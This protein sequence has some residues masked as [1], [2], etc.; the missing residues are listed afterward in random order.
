[1]SHGS[2]NRSATLAAHRL[3]RGGFALPASIF[4]LMV[5]A[6]LIT[7]GFYLAG[8]ESRI[9]Q[10]SHRATQAFYL[11][12]TGM[13]EVLAAWTPAQ[14]NLG[15]WDTTSACVACQGEQGD[16]EWLVT[17][18]RVDDLLYLV[19]S[20][21]EITQ[22]GRLA[23]ASRVLAQLA[24]GGRLELVESQAAVTTQ[25]QLEMSGNSTVDGRDTNGGGSNWFMN[26]GS[27]ACPAASGGRPAILVDEDAEV[28]TG[29]NSQTLAPPGVDPIARDDGMTAESMEMFE[30][31]NWEA[32]TS[33]ANKY[34]EASG[35]HSIGP[36]LSGSEC[37]TTDPLN[38][39]APVRLT[40][41][42]RTAS[43]ACANFFPIIHIKVPDN[44]DRFQIN[45]NSTGQGILLVEGNLHLNGDFNWAG[46]IYVKGRFTNNGGTGIYGSVTSEGTEITTNQDEQS[47]SG[48]ALITYSSCGLSKAISGA[49][50][51]LPLSPVANRG[52]ADLSAGG[53]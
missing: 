50:G 43:E 22:G 6:V 34:I 19:E 31:D 3:G 45:A 12:E 42:R 46:P 28:D 17:I 33:L 35:P 36:S 14:S 32:L 53:F 29:G 9:G 30:P 24:R 48:N 7:S 5:V 10:S 26:Q 25:N 38:W 40:G 21:G 15:V 44:A 37:N 13:N 27:A 1:M 20:T 11:A 18:T 4:A 23:G 16:G 49:S 51:A 52:W 2:M 39:G 8:Q 47:I 41:N